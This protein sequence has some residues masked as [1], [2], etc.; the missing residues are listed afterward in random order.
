MHLN[1]FCH[2]VILHKLKRLIVK[3]NFAINCYKLL[4]ADVEGT[5]NYHYCQQILRFH[6]EHGPKVDAP[7]KRFECHGNQFA[8]IIE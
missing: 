7:S 5:T 4:S 8:I 6:F 1:G 3:L 2:A